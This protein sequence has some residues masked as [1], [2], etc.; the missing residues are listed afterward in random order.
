MM[1]QPA[2]GRASTRWSLWLSV[3]LSLTMCFG[4]VS[5]AN[6]CVPRNLREI[7][8]IP[9]DAS[10]KTD[11]EL[12][13]FR[14]FRISYLASRAEGSLAPAIRAFLMG[15][16][17]GHNGIYGVCQNEMTQARLL[18]RVSEHAPKAIG[19]WAN[20]I[21]FVHLFVSVHADLAGPFQDSIQA[22]I[23]SVRADESFGTK[24]LQSHLYVR[25]VKDRSVRLQI[26]TTKRNIGIEMPIWEF[27][28]PAFTEGLRRPLCTADSM[29]RFL[30]KFPG[31][32]LEGI[33]AG[34]LQEMSFYLKPFED[35]AQEV[36]KLGWEGHALIRFSKI[37]RRARSS[38]SQ[39]QSS[40]EWLPPS[41]PM[42]PIEVRSEPDCAKLLK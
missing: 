21:P 27:M 13:E 36:A 31:V 15:D 1:H 35:D 33:S 17:S 6:A 41:I 42:F 18:L 32:D 34:D 19:G 25:E 3:S 12:E 30:R 10:V 23:N 39:R 38:F 26:A 7:R 22:V 5:P 9:N 16:Y 28:H 8:P 20:K 37:T 29:L 14:V 40:E 24:V 11:A 4:E 2:I